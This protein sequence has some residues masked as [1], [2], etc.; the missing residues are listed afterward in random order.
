MKKAVKVLSLAFIYSSLDKL[1]F[2]NS[3]ELPHC[4]FLLSSNTSASPPHPTY[5]ASISFSCSVAALFSL[6]IL[7]KVLI[8]L[9]LFSSLSPGVSFLGKTSS[10]IL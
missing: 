4:P 1:D 10:L 2:K 7:I 5:L 9:I 6:S 3:L 8:A